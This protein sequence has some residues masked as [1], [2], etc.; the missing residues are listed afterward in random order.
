MPTCPA[1]T[2]TGPAPTPAVSAGP[3]RRAVSRAATREYVRVPYADVSAFR[4]PDS[5]D[6]DRAV[7]AADVAPTGWLAAELGAVRP[8]DVVAIWGAGAATLGK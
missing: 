5:V 7:F 6:D 8:G 2:P 1:P 4:V 3:G